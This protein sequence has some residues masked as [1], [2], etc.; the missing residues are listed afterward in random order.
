MSTYDYYKAWQT[1]PDTKNEHMCLCTCYA[2]YHLCELNFKK[3]MPLAMVKHQLHAMELKAQGT[4]TEQNWE[5]MLVRRGQNA[6]EMPKDFP[7]VGAP[8]VNGWRIYDV[9]GAYT[10][11]QPRGA[12]TIL[13]EGKLVH[14]RCNCTCSPCMT[15]CAEVPIK[16]AVKQ[17]QS[18]EN[19]P[20]LQKL[21]VDVD[22]TTTGE[23]PPPSPISH[24]PSPI[25][26]PLAPPIIPTSTE[27]TKPFQRPP[28]PMSPNI[29]W[30]YAR[31]KLVYKVLRN[32]EEDPSIIKNHN[33]LLNWLSWWFG[34]YLEEFMDKP[35]WTLVQEKRLYFSLQEKNRLLANYPSTS[36]MGSKLRVAFHSTHAQ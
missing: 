13:H 30:P 12:T 16:K 31:C 17:K 2:C 9:Q 33:K 22:L 5:G 6:P 35:L 21:E 10:Y 20:K 19:Q 28:K 8:Y 15:L 27:E 1:H 4:Y 25:V 34:V 26:S 3:V 32:G 36:G 11:T 18:E 29:N 24:V 14:C 7:P 23:T